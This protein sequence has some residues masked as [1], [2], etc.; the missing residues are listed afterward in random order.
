MKECRWIKA[1]VAV[2]LAL[3]IVYMALVY[4]LDPV[5][6]YHAPWFGLKAQ[7]G[8]ARYN[9]YGIARNVEFDSVILGA[10]TFR[11]A[12]TSDYNELYDANAARIV[13]IAGYYREQSDWLNFAYEKK[14]TLKN[15]FWALDARGLL[16][17]KDEYHYPDIPTYLYDD[18]PLNDISYLLNK[19]MVP[20][21]MRMVSN[22]TPLDFDSSDWRDD[23]G[24]DA[25]LSVYER[26]GRVAE[27]LPVD[28]AFIELVEGNIRQ[29]IESIVAAHPETQFSFAFP[30]V[31]MAYW[32]GVI[33][34][35]ELDRVMAA[36]RIAYDILSQY[37]N[38]RVYSFFDDE[39]IALNFDLY[40]DTV[41]FVPEICTELFEKMAAG[42]YLLTD[43]TI[44][45]RIAAQRE[46]IEGYDYEALFVEGE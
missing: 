29:N 4:V 7:N 23:T 13:F 12:K 30:P 28:E 33:R 17:G 10:S 25:V 5:M 16:I 22:H 42:E 19:D 37:E 35:G 31:N 11:Y 8:T 46:M 34:S 40:S 32:D 21:M 2:L 41:H 6:H 14:G 18:N 38:V 44:D 26:S 27:R 45:A 43:A 1:T 24:L 36:E 15:V 3:M 20:W 9:N 39:E